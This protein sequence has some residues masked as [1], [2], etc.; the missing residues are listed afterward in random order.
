MKLLKKEV[1]NQATN[2]PLS[3]LIIKENSK[4]VKI[5]KACNGSS[6]S[7]LP[8]WVKSLGLMIANIA[9]M[10]YS[11]TKFLKKSKFH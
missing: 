11:T 9:I 5:K 4:R 6:A 8:I 1:I 2:F 7:F 10:I 3:G